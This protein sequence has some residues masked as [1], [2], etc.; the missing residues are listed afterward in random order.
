MEQ[1][2]D[3][4]P[5]DIKN[6]LMYLIKGYSYSTIGDI[7]HF[8]RQYIHQVYKDN[9][10]NPEFKKLYKEIDNTRKYLNRKIK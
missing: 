7:M 5:I 3:K 10:E 8:S 4:R 2:N 1:C 6:V 9:K